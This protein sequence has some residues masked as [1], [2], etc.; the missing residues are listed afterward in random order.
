MKKILMALCLLA[1]LQAY[2]QVTVS[3]LIPPGGLLEKQQLWNLLIAN[4][5]SSIIHLRIQTVFT[6]VSS[7]EPVLSAA[8]GLITVPPGTKQISAA[9]IGPVQYNSLSSA[10]RIDPG[11]SG[12]LP[13]G[14]FNACYA[15]QADNGKTM[16]QECQ[17]IVIEPLSPLQL[18]SPLDG[19]VLETAQPTFTWLPLPTAQALSNLSYA[20]TLVEVYPGQSAVDALAKN[21]PL[22]T[23]S[24]L[25][26]ASL[27]YAPGAPALEPRKQYAWQVKALNQLREVTRSDSW[28]FT[29]GEKA[30]ATLLKPDPVYIKLEK[31]GREAGQATFYGHLRFAYL[32][33]TADTSWNLQLTEIGAPAHRQL[34]IQALDTL[35]LSRGENFID[36]PGKSIKG[37]Q[38]GHL[39]LLQQKNTR[40]EIWQ[41]RFLYRR[42]KQ[43]P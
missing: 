14:R 30:A 8:T 27:F 28:Q 2:N 32:N 18:N 9:T 21:L 19:S 39:Y 24:N 10:Y 6:E 5:G 33:E 17:P 25:A 43:Q 37:L 15:F 42:E 11:P 41:L 1:T 13:V 22:Y 16:A 20:L 23:S 12:L 26:T 36:I 35:P 4:S 7:G 3:L 29:V 34:K 38:D 40:G 31:E